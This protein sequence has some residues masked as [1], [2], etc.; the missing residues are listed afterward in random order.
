M[1]KRKRVGSNASA[2]EQIPNKRS[3]PTLAFEEHENSNSTRSAHSLTLLSQLAVPTPSSQISTTSSTTTSTTSTANLLSTKTNATRKGRTDDLDF[4]EKPESVSSSSSS[5]DRASRNICFLCAK[6]VQELKKGPQTRDQL[7]TATGF[8]R[9][10]VCT[11]LSV[12]KAIG[13]IHDSKKRG[14]IEWNQL[15]EKLLPNLSSHITKVIEMRKENRSLRQKE[16]EL[17]KQLLLKCQERSASAVQRQQHLHH[18]QHQT[19]THAHSNHPHP[20][21]HQHPSHHAYQHSHLQ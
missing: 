20:H 1:E 18:L 21:T 2:F 7:A 13:L 4:Y 19:Q 16:S 8:A 10:R 5:C 6:L 9:Q 17:V 14:A 15:Q 11:V 12:Y 3:R